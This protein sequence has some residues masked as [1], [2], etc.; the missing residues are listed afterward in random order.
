MSFLS[1]ALYGRVSKDS[2]PSH[3]GPPVT[4]AQRN[5]LILAIADNLKPTGSLAHTSIRVDPFL[6]TSIV[7]WSFHIVTFSYTEVCGKLPWVIFTSL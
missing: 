2:F 6:D 4:R 1:H 5:S 7:D 3:S